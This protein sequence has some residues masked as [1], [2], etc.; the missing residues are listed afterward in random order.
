MCF[1]W[2][3]QVVPLKLP[4]G[5]D[6]LLADIDAGSHTPTLVSKVLAWKKSDPEQGKHEENG[7]IYIYIYIYMAWLIVYIINSKCT[8]ERAW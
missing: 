2:D 6:L 4:P 8:V 5:F 1:S 7:C 3:N